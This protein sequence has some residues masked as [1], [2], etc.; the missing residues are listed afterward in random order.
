MGWWG[1][2]TA[3]PGRGVREVSPPP[4]AR[5]W[6]WLSNR[7]RQRTGRP[8]L[9]LRSAVYLSAISDYEQQLPWKGVT[10]SW[11]VP[12]PNRSLKQGAK[13]GGWTSPS[14]IPRLRVLRNRRPPDW[15]CPSG[16][17]PI[18]GCFCNAT[19]QDHDASSWHGFNRGYGIFPCD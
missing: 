9:H 18:L 17:A 12:G 1:G 14:T 13:A 19:L 16:A 2:G 5:F 4:E 3:Q 8:V 11:L 10:E 6:M 15:K 7:I